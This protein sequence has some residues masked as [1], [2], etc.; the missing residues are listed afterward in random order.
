MGYQREI[1]ERIAG[2]LG[3]VK[4]LADAKVMVED[5]C[6]P[7]AEVEKAL[8]E[9]GVLVLVAV[10][11]HRRKTGVGAST[12]GDF[13]IEVSVF[14]NPQINR[15]GRPDALTVS[16][17]AEAV[18]KALHGQTVEFGDGSKTR[19]VYVDMARTDADNADFRMVVSFAAFKALDPSAGVKWGVDGEIV[20]EVV[21]KTMAR[22]GTP[23]FEPGRDGSARFVGT[24]DRH[25][26]ANV[27]CTV[28]AGLT[29]DDLPEIGAPFD[30]AGMT[31]ITEAAEMVSAG[32]DTSTVRL[33][34]RTIKEG[35]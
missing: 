9:L 7:H 13:A 21:T 11:G 4:S 22:G 35:Q 31:F 28:P 32:E 30:F 33:T 29:E 23:V 14:E 27:T 2:T 3:E 18:S 15:D 6:D 19:L 24:R 5:L 8:G 17:A 12:A 20:G 25:W 34:G 1:C 26:K 10:T 16:G